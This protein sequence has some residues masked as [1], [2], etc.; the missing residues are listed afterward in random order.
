MPHRPA[1]RL[2]A[3]PLH[4]ADP[5]AG[6]DAPAEPIRANLSAIEA[7]GPALF[8]GSD[9]GARIERLLRTDD[10]AGY[11]RHRSYALASFFDL[12]AGSDGEVD[13]EGLAVDGGWL[14]VTGSHSLARRKPKPDERDAAAALARLTDVKREPNRY[15]LG[16]IPLAGADPEPVRR[17]GPRT[18]ACVKMGD[19]RNALAKA[20]KHDAHIGRFLKVPAKENGF[21]VEGLA[22]RGDRVFLGLRGPVLRG[23]ACV[24]ELHPADA[25][26]GRLDI[27]P[28][29]AAGEPYR[30]H[31]LDLDGLGVRELAFDGDDLLILA[32]PTM[33]LDGPVIVYRWSGAAD[34]GDATIIPR[35]RLTR[36]LDLPHGTGFD[37]AEGMALLATPEG[38][39]LL[40]VYDNPGAGRLHADGSGVDADLFALPD[41]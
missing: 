21:D 25:G 15:L 1:E 14:W 11:G 3:V 23:W 36:T 27:T 30:K 20:L 22:V 13:V 17:D 8:V 4:P 34:V 24:L 37:H 26:N 28:I 9:E 32:G 33:D 29:G 40:V 38:P 12:P 35:D 39:R 5:D 10:S 31:F 19:R 18:A 16:R 6:S 2:R 41:R 7:A